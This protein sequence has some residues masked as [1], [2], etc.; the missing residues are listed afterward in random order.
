[1]ATWV[2]GYQGWLDITGST[3][4][5]TG[6]IQHL[7]VVTADGKLLVALPAPALPPK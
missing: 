6:D 4:I 1:M 2:A 5:P 3:A 7:A